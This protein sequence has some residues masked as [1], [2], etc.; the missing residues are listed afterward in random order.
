MRKQPSTFSDFYIRKSDQK[1]KT[2]A[3]VFCIIFGLLLLFSFLLKALISIGFV[4]IIS[5]VLAVFGAVIVFIGTFLPSLAISVLAPLKKV[6]S[7]IGTSVLRIILTPL[8]ILMFVP[9]ILMSKKAREKFGYH[10]WEEQAP[11]KTTY[12]SPDSKNVAQS[13]NGKAFLTISS[14]FSAFS[15][16]KMKILI[17]IVVILILLGLLFFFIASNPVLGFIYTLF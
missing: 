10:T 17:P 8:F 6:F 9:Y 2:E 5:I 11:E 14:L 4:E 3:S 1:A 13:D 15:A 12:F 7:F 16:I